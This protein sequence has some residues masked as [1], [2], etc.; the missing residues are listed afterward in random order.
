S[1]PSFIGMSRL[2]FLSFVERQ[3]DL[4]VEAFI[5]KPL[6]LF[7]GIGVE[8]VLASDPDLGER[9]SEKCRKLQGPVI[10]QPFMKDVAQGEV[11]AIFYKNKEIGS[12]LKVPVKGE[13]LA[14]I[15]QGAS[16]NL[17]ELNPLQKK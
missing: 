12:I 2:D 11:R 6:D 3:K 5:L 14:N 9:F 13:F 8:K 15:A 10:A 4:G 17:I 7:Q 1:I 16:F